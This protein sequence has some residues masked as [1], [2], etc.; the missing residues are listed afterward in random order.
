MIKGILWKI[1]TFNSFDI[2]KLGKEYDVVYV[3]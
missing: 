1:R 2:G 3:V